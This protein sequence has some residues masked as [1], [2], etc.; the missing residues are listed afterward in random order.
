MESSVAILSDHLSLMPSLMPADNYETM[1]EPSAKFKCASQGSGVKPSSKRPFKV[2]LVDEQ[3]GARKSWCKFINSF[4]DFA[5]V[6]ACP[7]GEE[8][9]RK[10]PQHQPDVVLVD[11]FLPRMSGIECTSR[12]KAL[13]PKTQIVML[14]TMEDMEWVFRA[15]QAGADGYL[16]KRTTPAE[17]RVALLDVLNGGA[18]LTNLI[19]RRM[20]ASFRQ[21]TKLRDPSP[22]LT[23]REEQILRL[24]AQ[25]HSNR[26]IAKKLA[27]SIDTVCSHLK[28]VFNKFKVS[29]RTQAAIRYMAFRNAPEARCLP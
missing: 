1:I 25:G 20:I 4:T 29:S 8:A 7:T 17:L 3:P 28:K 6:C 14:T 12:L 16:L 26:L 9:L 19:A 13:L 18:P 23:V 27:L 5:C 21:K 2:A 10:F 22:P 11:V 15:L 24:L